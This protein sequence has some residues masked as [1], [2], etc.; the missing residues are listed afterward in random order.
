MKIL[1]ILVFG[2]VGLIVV[3]LLVGFFMPTN[4]R[5]QR[6]I[7]VDAAP[8]AVQ[9]HV[10]DLSHWPEWNPCVSE[11]PRMTFSFEGEQA[12]VGSV[13]RWHSEKMGDGVVRMTKASPGEG[14]EYELSMEEFE[15]PARGSITLVRDG[16][17]TRVTWTD[18]G[19]VG[20]NPFMRLTLPLMEAMMG[21]Y[22]D[23][24]LAT[25]AANVE[26]VK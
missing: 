5:V 20:S 9:P 19:D 6:S 17:R 2:L 1:K 26:K 18:A 15:S 10:A 7:V 12:R 8:E 4:W 21:K 22:F 14:M 25:L 16:Q 13:M 11:D 24:G 3:L 23:R